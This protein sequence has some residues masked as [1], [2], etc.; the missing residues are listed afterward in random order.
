MLAR[1]YT[2]RTEKVLVAGE[3]RHSHRIRFSTK[4]TELLRIRQIDDRTGLSVQHSANVGSWEPTLECHDIRV[5][6]R[7][8]AIMWA[9]N[10]AVVDLLNVQHL[11]GAVIRVVTDDRLDPVTVGVYGDWGSGKSS[12][13]QLVRQQI[14]GD[15]DLLCVYFNGW[16]F[17]GYEDAKAALAA[18]ILEEIEAEAKK[19]TGKLQRV[20]RS[21]QRLVA[22]GAD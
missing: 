11:V 10:E 1:D 16:R 19:E 3:A 21:N 2:A 14:A 6:N 22:S 7:E 9:D 20:S 8:D 4:P 15:P 17:E 13:I 5:L 12:V 18:T